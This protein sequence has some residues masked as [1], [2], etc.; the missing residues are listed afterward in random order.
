M[1]NRTRVGTLIFFNRKLKVFF[2][3]HGKRTHRQD[4]QLFHRPGSCIAPIPHKTHSAQVVH[5]TK[6]DYHP[7]RNAHPITTT[8]TTKQKNLISIHLILHSRAA[9]PASTSQSRN[10]TFTHTVGTRQ[11]CHRIGKHLMREERGGGGGGMRGKGGGYKG[12][13]GEEER[14]RLAV[15][16]KLSLKKSFGRCARTLRERQRCP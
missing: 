2:F 15:H 10:H 3:K 4:G 12:K 6:L 5:S 16:I 14:G 7:R 8:T 1:H 9:R 11:P 13:S